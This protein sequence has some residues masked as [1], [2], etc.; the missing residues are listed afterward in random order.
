MN[1]K[2]II[3]ASVLSAA[4]VALIAAQAVFMPGPGSIASSDELSPT[5]SFFSSEKTYLEHIRAVSFEGIQLKEVTVKA[6]RNFWLIAR[7][8]GIN[9][10]T[11][12]SANPFWKDLNARSSQ[13]VVVPSTKGVIHF[14]RDFGQIE[15]VCALYS[16]ERKDIVVQKLPFLSRFTRVFEKNPEPIAVFVR[17]VKPASS[18]MQTSMAKSFEARELFRSPLGG[19]FSSYFGRRLDPIVH[20]G[21]FHNGL[22]IATGMGTPVG[23]A[24]GGVVEDAGWMGGYGKAVIINHQNGY[25]TLYG[26]LSQITTRPGAKIKPGSLIGR[27]GSTG[28]STGPHLHFTVWHNG[29]LVNPMQLLW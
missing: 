21:Q 27:V 26:H 22:D 4:A 8:Y 12:I 17:D 28:W 15:K 5:F 6:G 23:A 24:A 10:D 20:T 2:T 14:V 9:I 18:M 7:D 19:R 3:S 13:T 16:A 29:Q 11:L 25:K 1:I